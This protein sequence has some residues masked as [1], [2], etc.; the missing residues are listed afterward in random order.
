MQKTACRCRKPNVNAEKSVSIQK[1]ECQ[2]RNQYFDAENNH[3][4]AENSCF[5][6]TQSSNMVIFCITRSN[7]GCKIAKPTAFR[8]GVYYTACC[9]MAV[10]LIR[11]YQTLTSAVLICR[12]RHHII[13][14]LLD[15]KCNK[16]GQID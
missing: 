9:V 2:C 8:L 3:S 7:C 15:F 10:K 11:L 16:N 6:I 1:T 5:Y 14:H 13:I 4:V 12:V